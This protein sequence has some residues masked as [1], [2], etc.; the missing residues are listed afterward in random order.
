MSLTYNF[1]KLI[2]RKDIDTQSSY[3]SIYITGKRLKIRNCSIQ[4]FQKIPGKGILVAFYIPDQ[5]IIDIIMEIDN[6]AQSHVEKHNSKWFKNRMST[7]QIDE[8]YQP[9]LMNSHTIQMLVPENSIDNQLY[10]LN[11]EDKSKKKYLI[12]IDPFELIINKRSFNIRWILK[13]IKE[14]MPILKGDYTDITPLD[15]DERI[16]HERLTMD[17]NKA[18]KDIEDKISILNQKKE[19][20]KDLDKNLDK[21]PDINMYVCVLDQL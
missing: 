21:N 20:I 10:D 19:L 2:R 3:Y 9:S 4:L 14:H 8:Y 12:D 15:D 11:L 18:L 17:I 7:D 5:D 13:S 1:G 6:A 16:L